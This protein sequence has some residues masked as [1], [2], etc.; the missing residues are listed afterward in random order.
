MSGKVILSYPGKKSKRSILQSKAPSLKFREIRTQREYEEDFAAF[1]Q[2]SQKEGPFGV[3]F[4]GNNFYRFTLNPSQ[5][6][7]EYC[8]PFPVQRT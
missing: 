8:G 2:E 1:L 5:H 3:Y 7:R 4:I 6:S